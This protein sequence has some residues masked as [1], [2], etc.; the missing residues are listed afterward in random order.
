MKW[1]CLFVVKLRFSM[2]NQVPG[3]GLFSLPSDYF[4]GV[5]KNTSHCSV[6]SIC[7]TSPAL[8]KG[9]QFWQSPK[10]K[11]PTRGKIWGTLNF[12]H[13]ELASL[14]WRAREAGLQ[15]TVCFQVTGQAHHYQQISQRVNNTDKVRV[16]WASLPKMEQC[17]I[18]TCIK[19]S[20]FIL[21]TLLK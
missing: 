20:M 2:Q 4:A 8:W 12:Q 21:L 11:P 13:Q 1:P 3:H 19:R 17:F 5:R 9:A 7:K 15:R 6:S 10:R 18:T 14:L 16:I